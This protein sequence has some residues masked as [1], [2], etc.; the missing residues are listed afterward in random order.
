MTKGGPIKLYAMADL[1]EDRLQSVST[2]LKDNVRRRRWTCRPNGSSS[3]S[4]PTRRRSTV[5]GPATSCLLTTHAAFRPM[6]LEYAVQ[7]GVNVFAEKSFATDGPAV[8]RWLKAAELAEQ[9]NLKVSVGFMWRHSQARQEVINRIHDGAIGDVHT[10]RIY[11]V[12]GP[13]QCPPRPKDAE[14]NRVPDCG[15]PTASPGSRPGSSS[16]GT[17]TTST[18]PAGPRT[19]GR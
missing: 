14:R 7:K 10:L 6:H 15:T 4:T 5:W 3:G 11:R 2:R 12:H 13:V 9:K 16:T 1:F 17:A 19:P 18:S 8:R